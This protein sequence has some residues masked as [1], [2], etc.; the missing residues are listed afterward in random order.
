MNNEER[1]RYE[2]NFYGSNLYFT[3]IDFFI[4]LLRH[5][6]EV[7]DTKYNVGNKDFDL[8][9]LSFNASDDST[10]VTFEGALS[11]GLENRS[12]TGR[13][14]IDD[15]GYYVF[16][17]VYRLCVPGLS[18]AEKQYSVHDIF[19]VSKKGIKHDT[20]YFSPS[21]DENEKRRYENR[22]FSFD[23]DDYIEFQKRKIK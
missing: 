20:I 6:K 7:S 2:K 18:D 17:D 13:I 4:Q 19:K 21:M 14:R 16:T 1:L 15:K 8:V 23:R 3:E 12:I 5:T 22:K 11:N 9:F 10:F